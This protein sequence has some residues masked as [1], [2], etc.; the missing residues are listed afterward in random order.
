MVFA[1]ARYMAL[2]QQSCQQ[3]PLG[4]ITA[5]ASVFGQIVLSGLPSGNDFVR[6][7]VYVPGLADKFGMA[8]HR[9]FDGQPQ[10]TESPNRTIA[11]FLI[12]SG[13]WPSGGW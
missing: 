1:R 9:S 6:S 8:A 10:T 5:A 12:H 4:R 3:P 2:T 13:I 11:N 7:P